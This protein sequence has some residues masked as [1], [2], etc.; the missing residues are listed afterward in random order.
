MQGK[1]TFNHPITVMSMTM[2]GLSNQE[3]Q[4]IRN[5]LCKDAE[6]LLKMAN[7]TDGH[8]G[9]IVSGIRTTQSSM[10]LTAKKLWGMFQNQISNQNK[11]E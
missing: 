1:T 11:S 8:L 2:N 4:E 6:F 9:D 5:E 7:S 10:D 3:F